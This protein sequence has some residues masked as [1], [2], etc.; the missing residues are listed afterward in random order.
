MR[1]LALVTA[2]VS[3]TVALLVGATA[4]SAAE[5]S[6]V[7]GLYK[8]EETEIADN[9]AGKITTIGAGGRFSDQLDARMYWFGQGVLTM[10]SYDKGDN[11]DAP[12]DSTSLALGGG[13]R[14][15]FTKLAESVAPF[16]YGLGQYKSEKTASG[17][18]S[19]FTESEDNGLFYGASFGIRLSLDTDFFVDF[20]SQLF[21]SALFATRKTEHTSYDAGT[22]KKTTTKDETK[23]T[24]LW[25]QS[26]GP[27]ENM[28]IALGMRI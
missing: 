16:A 10:R 11:E 23:R 25:V 27:F 7:S 9:D 21:E 22:G 19:G 8:S 17:T 3:L 1:T 12:S 15:Y 5:V 2:P 13:V 4:A 18:G 14:Y 26:S 20:E 24:E 28:I 6:F